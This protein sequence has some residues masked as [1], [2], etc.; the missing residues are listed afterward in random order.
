[1]HLSG[2][3]RADTLFAVLSNRRRRMLIRLLHECSD[4]ELCLSAAAERIAAAELN[5]QIA[6]ITG[7]ERKTRYISLYQT[8]APMMDD[9]EICSY[10][11]RKQ[12]ITRDTHFQLTHDI[13]YWVDYKL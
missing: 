8:H 2:P 6:E 7:E 12:C 4:E 9:A 3:E 5:T 13:L 10:N 1:M 11:A